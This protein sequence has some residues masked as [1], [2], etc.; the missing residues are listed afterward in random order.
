MNKVLLVMAVACVSLWSQTTT[1]SGN[2][3]IEGSQNF[4]VDSSGSG[5]NY[6][7]SNPTGGKIKV[8]QPGYFQY[9][10]AAHA[11][12]GPVTVNI[13]S[14]GPVAVVRNGSTA[15]V[16][17]DIAAGAPVLILY[18]GTRFQLLTPSANASGGSGITALTGEVSASG[19]GSVSASLST[20]GV[21]AGT[22]GSSSQSPVI[23]VDAKGRLTNVTTAS[24]SGGPGGSGISYG[25]SASAG[26]NTASTPGSLYFETD[27]PA[28]QS[29]FAVRLTS[30]G[31][32]VPLLSAGPSGFLT[33]SSNGTQIDA[34]SNYGYTGSK[35]IGGCTLNFSNGILLTVTGC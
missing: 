7:L 3:T 4:G 6:V 13:D 32:I 20:T 26:S 22:Y 16:A 15:L 25:A 24:I 19:T 29:P 21:T 9:Y 8:Y 33:M 30:G 27:A 35:T 17:G 11:N 28:T 5:S 12:T 10:I 18:D 14:V 23:T 31:S 34:T 1:I 2:R